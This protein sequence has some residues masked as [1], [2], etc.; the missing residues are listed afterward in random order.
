MMNVLII[1]TFIVAAILYWGFTVITLKNLS[2]NFPGVCSDEGITEDTSMVDIVPWIVP[3]GY[4]YSINLKITAK[5]LCLIPTGIW[6]WIPAISIPF[7]Q[8]TVVN[9]KEGM[10]SVI[11]LAVRT[12]RTR[13]F[14]RG[15]GA[16][17]IKER[18][19]MGVVTVAGKDSAPHTP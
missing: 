13:I 12:Q 10:F 3:A 14:V 1:G 11:E 15:D 7:D 6:G 18:A 9:Y 5:S 2:R 16:R 17:I 4:R 8:L 19:N